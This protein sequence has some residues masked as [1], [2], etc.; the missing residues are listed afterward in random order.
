M[1]RNGQRAYSFAR[2]DYQP[3]SSFASVSEVKAVA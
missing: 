3:V 1:V 2:F